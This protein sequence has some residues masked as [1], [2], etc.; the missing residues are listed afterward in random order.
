MK[1]QAVAA[2]VRLRV[3]GTVQGVGF[4][5]HVHRLAT[6]LGLAGSV[7][8]DSEG[9]LI[10]LSGPSGAITDFRRRLVTDA[11]A[12]A[13]IADVCEETTPP[14]DRPSPEGFTIGLSDAGDGQR[15]TAGAP[16]DTTTCRACLDE[17]HDPRDRRYRHPFITCTDC[18]PRFTI[19][20]SLP[21]D[22]PATTMADFDLCGPCTEEYHDPSDRRFHAQPIACHECGPGLWFDGQGGRGRALTD[23]ALAAAQSALRQGRIVAVKGIGGYHLACRAD[24]TAVVARL[25][26][27]KQRPGKPFALLVRD[28]DDARSIAHVDDVE[29]EALS[30]PAA[31]IVL[32]RRRDNAAAAARIAAGQVAPGNPLIGVMLASNPLHR[33][34]LEPVPGIASAPPAVLVMTSGNLSEEPICTDD[35]DARRRL[36][37]IAD[38]FLAHDRPIAVPCDD[39]V[40]RVLDGQPVVL[41]RSRGFVPTAVRL[42][43]PGAAA[44]GLGGQLK[45]TVCLTDGTQAWLSQHIGDMG[46]L[47]ALE[48]FQRSVER[49]RTMYRVRPR[50]LACD[51]HPDHTAHAWARRHADGVPVMPIQHHHAHV[52]ALMVESGLTGPVIGVAFD[53]TGFGR[54][55]DGSAQ[56]WGGEILIATLQDARRAAH[57]SLVALPGGDAAIRHPRRVALS[58]LRAAG[59]DW[60]AD[61]APV[62]ATD[63]DER[64][65]IAA[66][67]DQGVNTVPTSSMGR[68]FD[69]VSSL[70]GIR[71]DITYEA[72][73]AIELEIVADDHRRRGGR[74]AELI[75]PLM[76]DARVGQADAS[77]PGVLHAPTLVH[78]IV[79]ALRAGEP[80]GAIA[81]GFH[82]AVAHAVSTVAED[83]A[84]R[85]GVRDVCL[86][87]G[88]FAN[89]LL[90]SLTT[91]RLR[92][93]GLTPHRHRVVPPNDGGL[94]L[95]QAAIASAS[96][97]NIGQPLQE[98]GAPCA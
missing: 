22:R 81:L 50:V 36:G 84:R 78:T 98:R 40:V 73:A 5:P 76:W 72:Q 54:A 38:A 66:Q 48:A 10:E 8:N 19:S 92:D 75:L 39:S 2:H 13:V 65:V 87:G 67:I 3:R 49:T 62:V 43:A 4:R 74:T 44:L 46:S 14:G 96:A 64:A 15:R 45:S 89:A 85:T 30:G 25:R 90:L 68:L 23:A 95:G 47:P 83:L 31:P 93:V 7:R 11:P 18:G 9:V 97:K 29:A 6:S 24:D 34:L 33:L 77:E 69:A 53:G 59:L 28:L 21:Y 58:H 27:R 20:R 42:P 52:T 1:G 94:A 56:I 55:P 70:L 80:V 86:T 79:A 41:R 32:L 37:D 82:V 35:S 17:L 51:A 63:V 61:L 71:H 91:D 88:V 26:Q 16:P 57:L 60:A 12:L